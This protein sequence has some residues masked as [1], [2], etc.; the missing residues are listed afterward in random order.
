MNSTAV[1]DKAKYD[2]APDANGFNTES[3]SEKSGFISAVDENPVKTADDEPLI[4]ES[5]GKLGTATAQ[6]ANISIANV[7]KSVFNANN[8][9]LVEDNVDYSESQSAEERGELSST[10]YEQWVRSIRASLKQFCNP[11][12]VRSNYEFSQVVRQAKNLTTQDALILYVLSH[13]SLKLISKFGD[14][15]VNKYVSLF[16]EQFDLNRSVYMNCMCIC[17][18][19]THIHANFFFSETIRLAQRSYGTSYFSPKGYESWVC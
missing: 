19:L 6:T 8:N 13:P 2:S 9:A 7:G 3:N 12:D 14:V 5:D 1:H 18:V 16:I 11:E 17:V 4:H 15:L 10:L